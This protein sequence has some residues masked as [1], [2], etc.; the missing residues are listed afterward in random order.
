MVTDNYNV[1]SPYIYICAYMT[2]APKH[3]NEETKDQ[4]HRHLMWKITNMTKKIMKV[5]M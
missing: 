4:L 2:P 1:N 3:R 5:I